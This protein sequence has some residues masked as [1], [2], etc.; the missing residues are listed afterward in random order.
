[1][2]RL[3]IDF[4]SDESA[5]LFVQGC[6]DLGALRGDVVVREPSDHEVMTADIDSALIVDHQLSKKPG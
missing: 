1:M 4:P 3:L 5:R 2:T 6:R